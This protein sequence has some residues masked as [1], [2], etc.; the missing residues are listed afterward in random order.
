MHSKRSS[1]SECPCSR[2]GRTGIPSQVQPK[3][4]QDQDA[5]SGA[6]RLAGLAHVALY[7]PQ[8]VPISAPV[9]AGYKASVDPHCALPMSITKLRLLLYF[10]MG[11]HLL[12][13]EQGRLARPGVPRQLRTCTFRSNGTFQC[14]PWVMSTAYSNACILGFDWAWQSSLMMRTMP[15]RLWCGTSRPSLIGHCWLNGCCECPPLFHPVAD[16][17]HTR[18]QIAICMHLKMD[19][20]GNGRWECAETW[21][22]SIAP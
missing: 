18:A 13:D 4:G 20:L 10:R 21:F 6:I 2:E 1:M 9:S 11:S 16:L 5:F 17:N 12:H 3:L 7:C 15:C 19:P 14:L 22:P 8:R